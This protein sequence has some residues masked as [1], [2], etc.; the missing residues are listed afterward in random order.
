MYYTLLN[1]EEPIINKINNIS[2]TITWSKE[3][4]PDTH[5]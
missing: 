1:A 4:K 3:F 5:P 2:V